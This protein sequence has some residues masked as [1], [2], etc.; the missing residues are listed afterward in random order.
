MNALVTALIVYRIVTIHNEIR[1][2]NTTS[3]NQA[4]AH[5]DSDGRRDINLLISILIESGLITFVGQLAQS[6]MFR[7]AGN[8]FP[9]ISGSV[10]MFYVRASG[11]CRLL[12][13]CFNHLLITQ[14]ISMI[15]VLVRVETGDSLDHN[16]IRRAV[17]SMDS[18]RSTPLKFQVNQTTGCT[19]VG[20]FDSFNE[21]HP[22]SSYTQIDTGTSP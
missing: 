9:L 12:F 3:N 21:A 14:G 16:T 10:V 18:G 8:T 2:F 7:F 11:S 5:G 19:E 1:E 17:N 15:V 13:W 20:R 4:S 6:I 22:E